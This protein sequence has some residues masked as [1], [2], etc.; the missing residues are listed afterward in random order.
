MKRKWIIV[1]VTLVATVLLVMSLNTGFADETS[2]KNKGYL[3]VS[4]EELDRH[5]KKELQADFGVVITRIELDSPADEFGLMEDDVIQNVNDIKIRRPQT[6]T[7]IIRKIQPGETASIRVI[8]D[9]KSKTIKVVIGKLKKS[10]N[11]SYFYGGDDVNVFSFFEKGS[12]YLGVHLQELNEDLAPYFKVKPGE[13]ALIMEVEEDSPAEEAGL[14]SG[15]VILKVDGEKTGCPE[16]VTEIISE[17]EEDEEVELT[18]LRKGKTQ[19]IKAVLADRKDF[20]KL[21]FAPHGVSSKQIKIGK[22]NKL[23]Q[24]FENDR[25]K[26][27]EKQIKIKTGKKIK[28]LHGTI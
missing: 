27:P 1:T 24:I 28:N 13:G 12:G 4:I 21:L 25:G 2:K 10:H 20:N 26:K 15:D 5:S 8:R 14:K 22:D 6:L 16:D 3:G 9:G 11:L 7:R 19:K 23:I 18:I 17:F